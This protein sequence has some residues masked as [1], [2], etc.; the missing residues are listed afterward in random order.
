MSARKLFTVFC[1][2]VGGGASGASGGGGGASGGGASG[3]SGVIIKE[4]LDTESLNGS[5]I[6]F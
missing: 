1:S 5:W 3:A 2:H 6:H 4:S